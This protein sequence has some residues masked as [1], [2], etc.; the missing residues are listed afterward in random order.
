MLEYENSQNRDIMKRKSIQSYQ[1]KFCKYYVPVERS[2]ELQNKIAEIMTYNITYKDA[3]H[4]VCA[5][6]AECDYF[7]TTDIRL[8]KRYKDKEIVIVNPLDFIDITEEGI[9]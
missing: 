2:E 5:I 6:F 4:I 7:L 8:Q 3:T 9:L 1:D